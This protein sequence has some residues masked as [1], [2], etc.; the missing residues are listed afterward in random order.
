M[1]MFYTVDNCKIHQKD[2]ENS[3][4][5]SHQQYFGCFDYNESEA[6]IRQFGLDNDLLVNSMGNGTMIYENHD[7]YDIVRLNILNRNALLSQPERICVCILK[8]VLLFFSDHCLP[9]EKILNQIISDSNAN[10]GFDRLLS[11]FFER[12]T[13]E[14]V[15][16]LENIEQEISDLE[17][18]L[19]S[20][21]KRDCVKEII[22][23]RKRLMILKRYYEQL[24]NILDELQENENNLLHANSLR[25]FKIF[26]GKVDRLYHSILNLR[27]YVTQVREAYQAEI[28]IS[29]NNIMKIFT[30]IT[31]IFLP[32]TLLVGW[33][34]M[35]LKMP[36]FQWSFAYP[37]VIILSVAIVVFCFCYFKKNKWF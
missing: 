9:V 34:G 19:I 25:Y 7:G 21:K 14:D 35:N 30:V 23:L 1:Q 6:V 18:A 27:D 31:A 20:S 3:K 15:T 22:S 37:F 11:T 2:M 29:L 28:D 16:F 8:N 24:L 32:L 26:S 4:L 36:E 17:N 12:I 33:Y 10:I 5:S 13:E